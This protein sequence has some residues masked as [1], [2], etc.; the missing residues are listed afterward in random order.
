MNKNRDPKWLKDIDVNLIVE[1]GTTKKTVD[2]ILLWRK[3]TTIKLEDS[4]VNQLKVYINNRQFGIGH[5]LR[6]TDGEMNLRLDKT[7]LQKGEELVV[8]E[9]PIN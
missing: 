7:T 6:N 8:S 4:T 9:N 2:E 5:I 3:G 1:V